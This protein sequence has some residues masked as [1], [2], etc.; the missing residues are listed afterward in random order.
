[1]ATNSTKF[2]EALYSEILPGLFQGGTADDD[3][4]HFYRAR[5]ER[6]PKL[7]FDSIVTLY[8]SA[9]PAGWNVQEFRYGIPDAHI[10][11]IDLNR[12]RRAVDFAHDQWKLGD[13]VLIRCQAGLNRS[14]LVTALV[15]MKDAFEAQEAIDLIRTERGEDA[16][17]NS[18]FERWIQSCAKSF[19]SP[20]ASLSA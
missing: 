3:V 10:S 13:Q 6:R 9:N 17:C 11:D 2:P 1:M 8:A 16:L 4:I 14:G 12:L 18:H 5:Y 20:S 7:P 15:L 19:I